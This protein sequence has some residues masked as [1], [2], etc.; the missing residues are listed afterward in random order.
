MKN[1][2]HS[3]LGKRKARREIR[4]VAFHFHSGD[5]LTKLK[6]A[7]TTK[8]FRGELSR[9]L[10]YRSFPETKVFLRLRLVTCHENTKSERVER[11]WVGFLI[12]VEAFIPMTVCPTVFSRS[13]FVSLL[14]VD[15]MQ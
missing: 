1:A 5:K 10:A 4:S 8:R 7:K 15:E 13:S 6:D 11:G 3:F 14:V 12:N 9:S 2:R